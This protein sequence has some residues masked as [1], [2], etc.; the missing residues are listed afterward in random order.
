M[1]RKG[2]AD[3][4]A[5]E[6]IRVMMESRG[7]TPYKLA[8]ESHL[9]ENTIANLFKRNSVP[10]IYTLDAICKGFGITLSQFFAETDNLV[11]VTPELEELF[12]SWKVLTPSQ[13]D[14]VLRLMQELNS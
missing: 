2:G 12:E 3:M 6:K 11:E 13:K 5:N 8:K 4:D 7:W 10:S 14:L 1:Y 9:S